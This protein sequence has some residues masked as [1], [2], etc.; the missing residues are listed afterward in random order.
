[1]FNTYFD[2]AE[3]F[4]LTDISQVENS[5]DRYLEQAKICLDHIKNN[6]HIYANEGTF[7]NTLKLNYVI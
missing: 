1:M 2:L 6:I 4:T 5:I 3:D 7:V